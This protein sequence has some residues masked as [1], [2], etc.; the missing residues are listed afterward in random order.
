MWTCLSRRVAW[1][2]RW[3]GWPDHVALGMAEVRES[4]QGGGGIPRE[5]DLPPPASLGRTDV[6]ELAAP[7]ALDDQSP[8]VPRVQIDVDSAKS[9]KFTHAK[10]RAD[11]EDDHGSPLRLGHPDEALGFLLGEALVV[12]ETIAKGGCRRRGRGTIPGGR[13]IV[14]RTFPAPPEAGLASIERP[15]VIRS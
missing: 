13:A 6:L 4:A 7:R 8:R 10:S 1:Q 5:G 2:E 11:R 12:V 15:F 3:V 14:R 9:L